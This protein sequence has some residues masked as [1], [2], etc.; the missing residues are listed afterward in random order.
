MEANTRAP[1]ALLKITA[2]PFAK[3]SKV[4]LWLSIFPGDLY[5]RNSLRPWADIV[6]P[7][8]RNELRPYTCVFSFTLKNTAGEFKNHARFER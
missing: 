5:G 2:S 3:P 4:S 8:G 1:G 6:S 7:G